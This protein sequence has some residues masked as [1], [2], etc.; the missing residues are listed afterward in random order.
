MRARAPG[1]L[2][3]SGAYAVLDGAPALVA[4]VD[5]YAVADT[6]RPPEFVSEEVRAALGERPAP[7]VDASALRAGDR[8]LGL[9]SSAAILV[10]SLAALE[11]ETAPELE[12]RALA[13][14]VLDRALRAHAEAQG[15]GSG[16]DV[17]ASAYG[18]VLLARRTRDGL[19][20]AARAL[21][22]RLAVSVFA[23][24]QAA[25]TRELVARVRALKSAEP[26]S[27]ARL[28]GAQAEAAAAAALA[29]E[30]DDAG[31]FVRAL[32]AQARAL[33]ALGDAAQAPIVTPELRALAE[34]GERSGAAVLP[35]GAGGGDVALWVSAEPSRSPPDHFPG[36]ERLRL[37]LGASGVSRVV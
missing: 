2:V 14:R 12:G 6:A 21:P 31:D 32:S 16:I 22:S 15:G 11:L 33:A 5:R 36:F 10:A 27:Y 20:L 19:E 29:L 7:F 30:R 26:S 24:G 35:A 8:K 25:S 23:A 3:I 34:E 13:E 28:L 9:G 4:A 17:A 37:S 18:G 1:K